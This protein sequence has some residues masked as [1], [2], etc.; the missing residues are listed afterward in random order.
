VTDAEQSTN[1]EMTDMYSRT[2]SYFYTENL[3][4]LIPLLLYFRA[5]CRRHQAMDDSKSSFLNS[6]KTEILFVGISIMMNNLELNS[7]C[8]TLNIGSC[9]ISATDSARLLGVLVSPTFLSSVTETSC[10]SRQCSLLFSASTAT[11]CS[12]VSG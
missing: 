6:D 7:A 4:T 11:T 1:T 10:F 3:I 8:L 2:R 12:A 5:L 9:T